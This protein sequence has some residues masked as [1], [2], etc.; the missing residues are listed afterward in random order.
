MAGLMC[1]SAKMKKQEQNPGERKL[2]FRTLGKTGI[3]VPVVGMGILL[4]GNAD[5]MRAALDA[6]ITHFDTTAS[7]IELVSRGTAEEL[8]HG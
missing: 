8:F 3:R 5:L 2:I 4:S 6:G 7:Y 1:F